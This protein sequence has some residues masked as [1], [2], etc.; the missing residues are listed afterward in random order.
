MR[1]R[2]VGASNTEIRKSSLEVERA[3]VAVVS[4]LSPVANRHILPVGRLYGAGSPQPAVPARARAGGRKSRGSISDGAR[5]PQARLGLAG[6]VRSVTGRIARPCG[7]PRHS[8]AVGS[9]AANS[10]AGRHPTR[11]GDTRGGVVGLAVVTGSTALPALVLLLF[12]LAFLALA[13][14]PL[15]VQLRLQ[16]W[17]G[18]ASLHLPTTAQRWQQHPVPVSTL[19]RPVPA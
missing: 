8:Q 18:P 17:D 4:V 19:R 1:A 10:L 6:A 12:T 3:T 11:T 2:G 15:G 9:S 14:A 5:L 7:G 16:F 13:A